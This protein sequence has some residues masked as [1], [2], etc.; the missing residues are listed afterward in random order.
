MV[1]RPWRIVSCGVYLRRSASVHTRRT[2]IYDVRADRVD[3][4]RASLDAERTLYRMIFKPHLHLCIYSVPP[5]CPASVFLWISLLRLVFARRPSNS[6]V[7]RA[8]LSIFLFGCPQNVS[9]A[10]P[11]TERFTPVYTLSCRVEQSPLVILRFGSLNNSGGG[12]RF[13]RMNFNCWSS[14][15]VVRRAVG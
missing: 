11:Y 5:L 9:H 13:W 15:C 14:S 7:C 6:F 12:E 4:R 2:R 8:G 3:R 1:V 10:F